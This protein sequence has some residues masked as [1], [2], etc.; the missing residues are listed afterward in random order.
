MTGADLNTVAKTYRLDARESLH[1]S[2]ENSHRVGVVEEISI[3]A[4]LLHISCEVRKNGNC[5]KP[6]EDSAYT[7]GVGDSLTKSV[8]FGDFKVCYIPNDAIK[9]FLVNIWI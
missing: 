1:I 2:A 9:S 5:A 7:E 3:G 4:D 8:F 6:A